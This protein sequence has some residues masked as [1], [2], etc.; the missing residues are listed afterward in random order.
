M[1]NI[2]LT[3]KIIAF[4]LILI[5]S[6]QTKSQAHCQVPCGIYDDYAKVMKML[7]DVETIEKAS[8]LIGELSIATDPQSQNQRVRWVKNKETHAQNLIITIADYFLT[9]RVKPEQSD[10]MERLKKHHLVIINAMKAK[11]NAEVSA[12]LRASVEALVLLYP[13]TE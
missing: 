9:Q 5:F 10:Y 2:L 4:A 13:K 7:Q 3:T 6:V 12:D 8:K 11:Q 1:K